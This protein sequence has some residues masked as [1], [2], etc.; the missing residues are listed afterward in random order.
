MKNVEQASL[1]V[2]NEGHYVDG[3][4]VYAHKFTTNWIKKVVADDIKKGNYRIGILNNGSF[5][6]CYIGRATDQKLQDRL[7]QHTNPNDDHY[8]DEDYYRYFYNTYAFD[9]KEGSKCVKTE[10]IAASKTDDTYNCDKYG[11]EYKLEG[12]KCVKKGT[13]KDEQNATKNE[14]TYS[15]PSG[16]TRSTINYTVKKGDTLSSIAKSNNVTV[17]AIK[18]ANKQEKIAY[19]FAVYINYDIIKMCILTYFI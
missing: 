13:V 6:V 16:Y 19:L 5:N 12:N 8:F 2:I 3:E 1:R 10:T 15:C 17:N 11:S 7:L 14:S 18:I 4:E 9:K